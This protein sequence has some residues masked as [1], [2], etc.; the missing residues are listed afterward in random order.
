LTSSET[1]TDEP[2][3]VCGNEG[4]GEITAVG[5]DVQDLKPGDWVIL[6]KQQGGTWISSSNVHARDIIRLPVEEFD[7]KFGEVHCA[8]ITVGSILL[9]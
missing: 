4:L 3:Y 6:N 8:T 1:G 5:N 7:Y 9:S 2:L